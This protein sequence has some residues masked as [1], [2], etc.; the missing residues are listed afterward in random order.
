MT[1]NEAILTE[2]EVT[3]D[4]AYELSLGLVLDSINRGRLGNAIDHAK[5]IAQIYRG[6]AEVRGL[7]NKEGKLWS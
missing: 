1:T 7:L 4:K 3:L 5:V 2:I 6:K